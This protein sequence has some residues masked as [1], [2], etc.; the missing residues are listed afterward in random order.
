MIDFEEQNIKTKQHI[1]GRISHLEKD[2]QDMLQMKDEIKHLEKDIIEMKDEIKPMKN[3]HETL[4][5]IKD[6]H[7]E[8]I[9]GIKHEIGEDMGG[10]KHGLKNFNHRISKIENQLTRVSEHEKEMEEELK[11]ESELLQRTKVKKNHQIVKDFGDMIVKEFPD[12]ILLV[13]SKQ[14]ESKGKAKVFDLLIVLRKGVNK[15]SIDIEPFHLKVSVSQ[16][17][18]ISPEI[19]DF[20]EFEEKDEIFEEIKNG[21]IVF[22]HE[23]LLNMIKKEEVT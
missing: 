2:M 16:D 12:K 3:V 21:E 19:M 10:I 4:E 17:T 6:K 15:G 13:L 7:R 22:A 20:E 11:K 9:R 14:S 8:D 1:G 23:D 18:K 5:Q